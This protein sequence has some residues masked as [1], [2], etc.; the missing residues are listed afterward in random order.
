[1]CGKVCSVQT[2]FSRVGSAAIC[3]APPSSSPLAAAALMAMSGI[4]RGRDSGG[5]LSS[6]SIYFFFWWPWVAEWKEAI[7][8]GSCP[9]ILS[10]FFFWW[11]WVAE[12]KEAI[13]GGY[14]P[15]ILSIFFLMAMSGW[16]KESD[17]GGFL[18]SHSICIIHWYVY[19]CIN[20]K[21]LY[22]FIY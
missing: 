4:T 8:G 3:A 9:P 15:P 5:F 14:C 19:M 2:F 6:H 17:S 11:P 7:Q 16:M 10:I 18:S 21:Q 1:M 20:D 12:W 22:F 13:Q